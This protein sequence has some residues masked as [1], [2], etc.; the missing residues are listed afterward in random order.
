MIVDITVGKSSSNYFTRT[1]D[2][3]A[4]RAFFLKSATGDSCV[5]EEQYLKTVKH[6]RSADMTVE[7]SHYIIV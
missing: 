3:R 7:T 4:N 5:T 2:V 6:V 1:F